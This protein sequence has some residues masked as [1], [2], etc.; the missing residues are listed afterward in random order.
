[1]CS[2][3]D[4][5][6]LSWKKRIAALTVEASGGF[7]HKPELLGGFLGDLEAYQLAHS[8]PTCQP[9]TRTLRHLQLDFM[10]LRKEAREAISLCKGMRDEQFR[11]STELV[12][13][14][15]EINGL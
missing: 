12:L 5:P 4:H 14:Q 1:M 15:S 7:F 9:G 11:L 8:D 10:Q 2:M 6:T 3:I 13:Q